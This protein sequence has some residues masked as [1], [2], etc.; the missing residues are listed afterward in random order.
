AATGQHVAQAVSAHGRP[1]SRVSA[2]DFI[3]G[4][5]TGGTAGGYGTADQRTSQSGFGRKAPV[6]VWDSRIVTTATVL[7]P[8]S[9]QIQGTVDQGMPTRSGVGQIHRD[10]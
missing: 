10:L 5:P 3:A 6:P 7:G 4:H 1:Q 2:I 8:G 9:W